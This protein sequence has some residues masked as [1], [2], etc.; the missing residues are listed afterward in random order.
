MN[1]VIKNGTLLLTSEEGFRT[2]KAD[3][4]ISGDRIAAI[5]SRPAD[6]FPDE[7]EDAAGM[8]VMPGLINAHTHAYMTELKGVADDVP[9]H[10]WLFEGVM[11]KEEAMTE[12]DA[13][14]SAALGLK[15][16]V[17]SG[18]TCFND[19]QMHIRQ[20][21]G[22]AVKLGM[23]G[24]IGRG[25]SG[26]LSEPVPGGSRRINEAIEE[27]EAFRDEPLLTFAMAP[28]APY[29]CSADLLGK[30]AEIAAARGLRLHI[31]LSESRRE[32]EECRAAH[33]GLTPIEYADAC[34]CFEVPA[35]A[36]H[37][38]HITEHDIEIL[39]DKNVS[40]ASNPASN[41]KLGNGFA[42]VPEMLSAGINVCLGT[43]GSASNNRLNMFHEMSLMALIHKGRREDPESVSAAQT[44]K[45]ATVCGAKALGLDAGEIAPGKLADLA[46]VDLSAL[47]MMP[48]AE[49]ASMLVYNATGAEVDSVMVGGKMIM[50]GR[51]F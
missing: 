33:G 45:M 46:F 8:L 10:Q 30:A 25:L 12:E 18:V 3:L 40:V 43:D 29:T 16:M 49:P 7:T 38:V 39:R 11:P 47:S 2:E 42:P 6:F 14:R 15:E 36:A 34:G 28:H 4:F 48:F 41:M 50:K 20:T 13:F 24:V 44:L 26:D 35:I 37:C 31:H 51:R 21:S 27:M 19:M 32:V 22:A 5:G 1:T 9:F 23:R 17:M